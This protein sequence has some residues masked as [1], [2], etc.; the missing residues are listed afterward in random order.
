L[1]LGLLSRVVV[2]A[3]GDRCARRPPPPKPADEAKYVAAANLDNYDRH[4]AALEVGGRKWVRPW[5]R[6][7]AF[8]YAEAS[9]VG[10]VYEPQR[11]CTSGFLPLLPMAMALGAGMGLDR[12]WVGLLAPNR[13]FAVG[14]ACFGR[15]TLRLTGDRG[16]AWR[17]CLLLT[18]FPYAFFFS[19]PYQESLG[20]ALTSAA[21]LAWLDRRPVATAA[22]LAVASLARLTTIA[23]S[24]ALIAEWLD[25][26]VHR[27]PARHVAWLVALSP[28]LGLGLF[29][30]YL[31]RH[32]GDPFAYFRAHAAWGRQ[33][34]SARN[35]VV[36]LE[37]LVDLAE[38]TPSFAVA[39]L[40]ILVWTCQR[41]VRAALGWLRAWVL[42]GRP[43]GVRHTPRREARRSGDR[44]GRREKGRAT[45]PSPPEPS[46][47]VE[48][49]PSGPGGSPWG[50]ANV[51]ALGLSLAA[52]S[53]AIPGNPLVPIVKELGKLGELLAMISF[54]GLGVHAWWRRGP[55]WGCLILMPV[56]QGMTTGTTLSMGR[57]VLAAF[58][59]FIDLA[60]LL[61]PRL[62]FS[63]WMIA[64]LIVQAMLIDRFVN[65]VFLG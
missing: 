57:I 50:V 39:G 21:L 36:L 59:A 8:W 55:F 1:I 42:E 27:R 43:Q 44:G 4:R 35:V 58:P 7:D 64:S 25:D 16:T 26:L 30:A 29:C 65:W 41:P 33:P 6:W 34:A 62:A 2:V 32:V 3:W 38:K 23:V 51:V 48:K 53:L 31:G 10:Y 40:A 46:P 20:L 61:R 60:E 56:V 22:S 13:A 9:Q 28:G 17:A 15:V 52:L 45:R 19:A 49:P 18:A 12:Y 24:L 14:L 63:A 47:A 5:Y 11:Q 37:A 54:L